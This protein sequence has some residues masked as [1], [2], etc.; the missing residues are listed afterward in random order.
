MRQSADSKD[1]KC[2]LVHQNRCEQDEGPTSR[3]PASEN[4]LARACGVAVQDWS[5]PP[6]GTL[7]GCRCERLAPAPLSHEVQQ[8][9]GRIQQRRVDT[10]GPDV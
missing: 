7:Q 3:G 10:V 9:V 2:L 6:G 5:I 4:G 8:A 1:A